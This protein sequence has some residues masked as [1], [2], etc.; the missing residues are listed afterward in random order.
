MTT[1]GKRTRPAN[2][3]ATEFERSWTWVKVSRTFRNLN[4]ICQAIEDGRRCLSKAELVHHLIS[5]A[6]RWDLRMEYR[7]LVSLC[8]RH[9]TPH[10]GDAG[11]WDYAP[12]KLLVENEWFVHPPRVRKMT[13]PTTNIP[14]EAKMA[15]LLA[16]V[17]NVDPDELLASLQKPN[18]R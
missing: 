4:P 15:E 9:H 13:T 5:P 11:L 3:A 7:N 18:R 6:V 8:Q 14:T 12:T 10:A 2:D 16:D 1:Y 17:Q